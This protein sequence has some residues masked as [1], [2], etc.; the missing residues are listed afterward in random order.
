M[1]IRISAKTNKSATLKLINHISSYLF[2]EECGEFRGQSKA[3]A[4]AFLKQLKSIL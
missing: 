1:G 4:E 3:K 2:E